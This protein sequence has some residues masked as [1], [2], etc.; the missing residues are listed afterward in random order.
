[1]NEDPLTLRFISNSNHIFCLPDQ[2]LSC[3]AISQTAMIFGAVK[4]LTRG[5]K[6]LNTQ[7]KEYS[8]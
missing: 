6:Q 2:K 7:T 4:T 5:Q 8:C 3:L 1:M